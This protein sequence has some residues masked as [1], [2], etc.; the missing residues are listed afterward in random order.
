MDAEIKAGITSTLYHLKQMVDDGTLE[1]DLY[2]R[3]LVEAAFDYILD[4]LDIDAL[5]VL[6]NITPGYMMNALL[7]QMNED[8]SFAHQVYI[9]ALHLTSHNLVSL[10]FTEEEKAVAQ[11]A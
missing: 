2:H 5:T 7:E 9:I 6:G 3:A 1:L 8:A 10:D 11:Q 4:D